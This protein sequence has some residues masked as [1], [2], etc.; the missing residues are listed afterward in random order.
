MRHILP[1]A[2]LAGKKVLILGSSWASDEEVVLPACYRLAQAHPELLVIVVPHEPTLANLEQVEHRIGENMSVVRFSNLHDYRDESVILVDSVGILMPLYRYA[3]VAYV[4]GSFGAGIHN[5]LEPAAYGL[6][7]VM[8]PR[9]QNSQEAVR[10]LR[11]GGAFTG[12]GTAEIF[13]HL[14]RLLSSE[15]DRTA[16]GAVALQLVKTNIGATDRFLATMENVL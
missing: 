16:A 12:Y 3:H 8:G 5:V 6:P 15:K 4:G 7:V 14:S 10:L 13:A 2:I 11:E 1:E 9:H